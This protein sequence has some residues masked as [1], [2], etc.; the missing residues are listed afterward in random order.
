MESGVKGLVGTIVAGVCAC[1]GVVVLVTTPAWST[2]SSVLGVGDP[3]AS[4]TDLTSGSA[5]TL[6][7]N[8]D[9]K[10][11]EEWWALVA[12]RSAT[13]DGGPATAG[14]DSD[15]DE[16]AAAGT[17]TEDD[18]LM[19]TAADALIL[20]DDIDVAEPADDAGYSR[21]EAFGGWAASGDGDGTTRDLVLTRDL[22]DVETDGGRVMSGTLEYDPYT[23]DTIDYE[24]GADSSGD[25]W[26][27]HIVG[28][29]DAWRS[30][31]ADW[32]RQERVAFANDPDTLLAVSGRTA[33]EKGD[34]FTTDGG[35][36][37]PADDTDACGYMAACVTVKHSYGLT[38]SVDEKQRTRE[39]LE[40]CTVTD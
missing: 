12:G 14:T 9:A 5:E 22:A 27:D 19:V 6:A 8:P 3:S 34:G 17:D 13:G 11:P 20:L 28:L 30:G 25:I 21:A 35:L 2:L 24:Y 32:T 31:A 15:A 37:T 26:I 18:E 1:A 29:E 16:D 23:G 40:S 33:Q 10:T 7:A 4:L 36:W 39:L 38:M